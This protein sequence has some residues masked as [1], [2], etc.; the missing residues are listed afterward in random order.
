M[1]VDELIRDGVCE[2]LEE[3]LSMF[4]IETIDDFMPARRTASPRKP[5]CA[6]P[7][8]GR[9]RN[10]PQESQA[11]PGE[12]ALGNGLRQHL[13]QELTTLEKARVFQ[14]PLDAGATDRR[15]AKPERG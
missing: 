1:L 4:P 15:D 10:G 8:P 2:D 3:V 9:C 14:Q 5:T 11:R 12:P 13:R 6:R 7:A